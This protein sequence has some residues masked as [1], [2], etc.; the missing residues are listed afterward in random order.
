MTHDH[1]RSPVEF[2]EGGWRGRVV[3]VTRIGGKAAYAATFLVAALVALILYGISIAGHKAPTPT[4]VQVLSKA[5]ERNEPWWQNLSDGQPGSVPRLP[6]T[7]PTPTGTAMSLAAVNGAGARPAVPNVEA[8]AASPRSRRLEVEAARAAQQRATL[9]AAAN[10]AIT[11][12][13]NSDAAP[14]ANEGQPVVTAGSVP[15]HQETLALPHSATTP[16]G[17]QDERTAFVADVAA[18]ARDQLPSVL[19]AGTT[20]FILRA[21]SVIPATLLTGVNSD[22]PGTVVAQV[23]EDV[24]DSI[25]TRFLI[26]PRGAKLTGVYDSRVVQGQRRVLVAWSRILYPDGSSLDLLGMPATDTVGQAGFGARV[27]EHLNKAFTSALLLSIIGAGAQLSQPQRAAS[28]LAAP[29]AGQV[30]AGAVGQ[31]LANTS[32][33][34]MQRE[35][36]IAPTLEVPPGYRCDVLVDRDIVLPAPYGDGSEGP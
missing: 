26:V 8:Q 7:T 1:V 13:L 20:P 5:S 21:G 25:E 4:E 32:M 16:V 36:G 31:Q 28:V 33:Q 3:G 30:I 10:A 27:D 24:Y 11:V 34:L 15:G 29:D 14:T 9:G 35:L 6:S 23:R 2:D 17:V 22:L 19:R 12:R 18:A